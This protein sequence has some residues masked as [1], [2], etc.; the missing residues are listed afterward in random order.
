MRNTPFSITKLEYNTFKNEKYLFI[1]LGTVFIM[2]F[3]SYNKFV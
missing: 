2:Q 1:M 3:K